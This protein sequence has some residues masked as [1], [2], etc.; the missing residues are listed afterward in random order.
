MARSARG[1][2]KFK[3]GVPDV[4]DLGSFSLKKGRGSLL[5]INHFAPQKAFRHIRSNL[6]SFVCACCW[7]EALE[8]L[9]LEAHTD[10]HELFAIALEI[11]KGL[12]GVK[13]PQLACRTL[14][15]GLD[16][17][18]HKT[19]FGSETASLPPGFK[20]LRSLV[21]R[22]EEVSGRQM[23]SWP[24]VLEVVQRVEA[25]QAVEVKVIR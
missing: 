25:I 10:S 24:S 17:A 11:L 16:A 7:I 3:T 20:K 8:H 4:L 1:G 15:E 6:N 22:I 12:D 21:L 13:E 2:T 5:F 14:C 9:T 19:G 18:L 23:K